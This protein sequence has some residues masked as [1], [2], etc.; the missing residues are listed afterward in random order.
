[1][2]IVKRKPE[3]HPKMYI[4]ESWKSTNQTAIRGLTPHEIYSLYTMDA[5]FLDTNFLID[6]M[7]HSTVIRC[8]VFAVPL[9]IIFLIRLVHTA[10]RCSSE[11]GAIGY[12]IKEDTP[13]PNDQSSAHSHNCSLSTSSLLYRLVGP[14]HFGIFLDQMPA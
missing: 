4:C 9:F 1:M 14:V 12:F 8:V 13:D 11:L 6:F 2:L 7:L 3:V 5:V 10:S